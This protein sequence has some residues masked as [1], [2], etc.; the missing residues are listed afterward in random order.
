M[1]Q[2]WLSIIIPVYGVEKYIEKCLDSIV[3]DN[4]D[5]VSGIEVL[6]ID[7]GSKDC[8]GEI[9]DR[10]ALQYPF[11]QVIHKQNAGVAAARNT[12]IQ[13][14]RGEWLYF[15]DSDDWMEKGVLEKVKQVTLR[16]KDC[17]LLLFDAWKNTGEKESQWEHFEEKQEWSDQSEIRQLQRGVLYFPSIQTHTP[18]AAPWDKLY[19]RVFVEENALFFTERLKVLD[20]MIF[21][22]EAFGVAKKI[23]YHKI[24]IYHYRYV[25]DSI[26]NSYKPDRIAQDMEVWDAIQTYI[27]EQVWE[28]EE[29]DAFLQA[30]YCRIVKS[31]SI[32]CRLCFFHKQNKK[33]L[34]E[35]LTYVK[36]V[37]ESNPYKTAFRKI[38][39]RNAE[40]KL[41]PMILFGRSKCAIGVWLLHL[42]Q[43][44]LCRLS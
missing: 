36:E 20:D 14:A 28:A 31:F 4:V 33:M 42:G 32:C 43:S 7:D 16:Q 25:P 6:V 13:H 18:L 3:K 1:T 38:S 34:T 41:K 23:S 44:L 17:D 40:W 27:N 30:Y 12:G 24:P 26:T 35:K 9:A 5:A 8:S 39:I 19:K 2:L 11:I 21:N 10:Y 29:E 15:M 22:M 37:L